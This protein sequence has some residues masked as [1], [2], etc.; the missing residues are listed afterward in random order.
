MRLIF[1]LDIEVWVRFAKAAFLTVRSVVDKYC[2]AGRE[3]HN[4]QKRRREPVNMTCHTVLKQE[5]AT[6]KDKRQGHK[7]AGSGRGGWVGVGRR[8]VE[9]T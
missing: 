5:N 7:G 3:S 1:V 9:G 6:R 4:R 8:G 2:E